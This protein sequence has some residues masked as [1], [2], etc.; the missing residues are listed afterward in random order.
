MSEK[1]LTAVH[2]QWSITKTYTEGE[3]H[4]EVILTIE[5]GAFRLLLKSRSVKLTDPCPCSIS[6][7]YFN[8][9]VVDIISK[10]LNEINNE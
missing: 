9:N 10:Y 8:G 2:Q 3:T 1:N 5:G 4:F 6:F 7:R